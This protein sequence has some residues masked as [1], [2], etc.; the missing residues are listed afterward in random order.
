MSDE[1]EPNPIRIIVLDRGFVV[2]CR[3]P[4][5]QDYALW[6]P[7]TDS[8]TVRRWGTTNGLAELCDGP[9]AETVLDA[10]VPVATYPVRAVLAV[11]ELTEKGRGA[12]EQA[13]RGR[14]AASTAR[15]AR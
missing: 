7:V 8:R 12:W 10:L 4:T 3:C 11:L 2:A 6:L 5:P 9:T 13:L 14:P 15:R 1:R